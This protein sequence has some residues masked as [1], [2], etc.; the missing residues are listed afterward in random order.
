MQAEVHLQYPENLQIEIKQFT[1][2]VNKG[3]KALRE[4]A[5]RW[6]ENIPELVSQKVNTRKAAIAR[7]SNFKSKLSNIVPLRKRD[8][9]AEKIVAPVK[10]KPS[11]L[12]PAPK[13][14][15]AEP[16]LSLTVYED[17]LKSIQSMVHVWERSPSVC[18]G[19]GEE[20]LRTILLV[21]L[22]GLY[23]GGATGE[24]FNGAGKT[25]ILIRHNDRNVFIAECLIWEGQATLQSKMDDQL[26][27]YATWRDSKL[28]VLVFN[29]NK[30][31]TDVIEKMRETVRKHPQ[32]VAPLP[33]SHPSGSRYTFKRND[34]A[35]RQFTLTRLAFDVPR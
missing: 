22:N 23:E 8:D 2:Q 4:D 3:L 11:P 21:G 20:D 33:F 16:E 35:Q 26:F 15:A 9:G 32:C 28:A 10:R 7:E 5:A 18:K 19:M 17:I 1:D 30:N 27:N 25:D 12:P 14:P 31:F 13:T 6:A 29:R 34:D 24:T